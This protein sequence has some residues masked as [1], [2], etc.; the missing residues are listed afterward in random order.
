MER[1]MYQLTQRTGPTPG[2]IFTLSQEE[3]TIGRETTNALPISDPEVSR[4]HARISFQNGY[5]ILEDLNSTNGTF[6]NGRRLVGQYVMQHGDVLNLGENITLVFE[7]TALDPDATVAS[8]TVFPQPEEAQPASVRATMPQQAPPSLPPDYGRQ[9]FGPGQAYSGQVP[10]NP[11][12]F[13]PM[14]RPQTRNR[15]LPWVLAGCGCLTIV[16]VVALA[17]LWY[18]DANYLW[19]SVFPFLP[20]CP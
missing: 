19:C 15:A 13:E 1:L 18:I 7:G 20:G 17:A 10:E 5:Y 4:R 14:P 12:E 3:I 8:T 16:C 11:D 9:P 2:K 6:V